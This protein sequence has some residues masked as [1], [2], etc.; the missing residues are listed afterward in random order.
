MRSMDC[1]GLVADKFCILLTREDTVANKLNVPIK[2]CSKYSNLLHDEM[3]LQLRNG[4]IL[5]VQIDL[6]SSEMMGLLCFF[7][8]FDLK[9]GEYMIFEYFGRFKFN[10]YIIGSDGSEIRYPE[11]NNCLPAIVTIGD[12]GWRFVKF[13]VEGDGV[14]DEIDPPV[15]FIERCG[16]ALPDRIIFVLSNG[17]KFAG[18]YNRE[19]GCFSGLSSMFRILGIENLKGVSKFLFTYDGTEVVSICAFDSE[20]YEIVFPGTPLDF[21]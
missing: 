13:R 7:K 16:F 18:S 6:V 15:G 10:V 8:H 2:F 4:Y 5:P 21:G 9:G 1:I 3:E 11:M 17:K 14:I 20:N 12:G 19:S